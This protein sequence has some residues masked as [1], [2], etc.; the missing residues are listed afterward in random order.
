MPEF[1]EQIR[2]TID[3]IDSERARLTE[4]FKTFSEADWKKPTFCSDWNTGQVVGHLTLGA[5]FYASTVSNGLVGN[6]GFPLGAKTK[7][8]FMGL[9]TSIM[10]DIAALDGGALVEK[11]N[12]D[13]Q[14][15]VSLFRSM[16]PE[17]LDKVGWH[18][19]GV[20][21]IPYFII[22]RIYE[23]ILHEWDIRN[24]P[25]S[26]LNPA[27]LGVAAKNLRW[28]FPILYNTQPDLKLEGRFR[29]ETPDTGDVWAMSIEKEKASFLED[30][31]SN[32]DA[33]ISA[34][35]S[36]MILMATGRADIDA[37]EAAGVLRTDGEPAKVKAIIASLFY[38]I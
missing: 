4:F 18:R 32:F 1:E 3:T 28:R 17:D 25:D 9:R 20:I 15:V 30:L 31:S 12:K 29:F 6:H 22:Q 35:A 7:E 16:G 24:E 33:S 38:P 2:L 8:E 14:E 10:N 36:D 34:P 23:F 11:F 27:A 37:K 13:T 19:R 21:P 26:P 5:Q